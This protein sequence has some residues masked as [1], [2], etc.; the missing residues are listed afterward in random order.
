MLTNGAPG[1]PLVKR[2]SA[3][4]MAADCTPF[5]HLHLLAKDLAYAQHEASVLSLELKTVEAELVRFREAAERGYGE[6]DM[7]SVVEIFRNP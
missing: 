3:R 2:L 7:S 6:Q 1:S 5:F 4:M